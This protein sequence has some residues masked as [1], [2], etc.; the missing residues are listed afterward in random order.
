MF[1]CDGVAGTVG[2]GAGTQAAPGRSGR[3]DKV[4]QA[5]SRMSAMYGSRRTWREKRLCG[6]TREDGHRPILGVT[7]LGGGVL[8]GGG[9]RCMKSGK[10]RKP[11]GALSGIGRYGRQTSVGNIQGSPKSQAQDGGKTNE[12]SSSG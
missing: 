1:S 10:P 11:T 2:S 3:E 8:G 12:Q 9:W 5:T 6:L 7:K 4:D